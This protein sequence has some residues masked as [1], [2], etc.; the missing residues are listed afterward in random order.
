MATTPFSEILHL[1]WKHLDVKQPQKHHINKPKHTHTH[2]TNPQRKLTQ[3]K[4][5]D[6]ALPKSTFVA[7]LSWRNWNCFFPKHLLPP[8]VPL[9]NSVKARSVPLAPPT[10][11]WIQ[12]ETWALRCGRGRREHGFCHGHTLS[13]G[14]CLDFFPDFS[15]LISAKLRQVECWEGRAAP[16][17]HPALTF[18]H[19]HGR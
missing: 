7:G 19:S 2:T 11:H 13:P 9:G 8:R 17:P 14:H 3:N 15:V 5:T 10:R 6:Y 12:P 4:N 18:H 1:I 16:R